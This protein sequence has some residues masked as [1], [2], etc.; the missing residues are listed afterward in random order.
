[1]SQVIIT[2]LLISLALTLALE[3]GFYLLVYAKKHS[4]RD[5]RLV[6]LVNIITNPIVVM[7]YWLATMY[8]TLN[9]AAIIIPLEILAVLTEGYYFKKYG[10]NFKHPYLF[11]LAVNAFS[12][13]AGLLIQLLI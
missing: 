1:M 10:E 9:P 2:S 4:I 6:I 3:T 8:T 7:S 5:L 13:T 12:Y 11:A